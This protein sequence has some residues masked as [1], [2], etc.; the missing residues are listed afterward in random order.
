MM[1]FPTPIS[2][3]NP[4]YTFSSSFSVLNFIFMSIINFKLVFLDRVTDMGLISFFYMWIHSF[5]QH[6]LLGML[7]FLQLI[8]L[9]ILSNIRW[10]KFC[11]F[12]Y[13]FVPSVQMSFCAGIF[14]L[15]HFGSLIYFKI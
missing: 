1:S 9:T 2:T 6:P 15:Y 10:V 3:P 14:G 7:S 4:A 11:A 13:D 8:F 12:M 5:L